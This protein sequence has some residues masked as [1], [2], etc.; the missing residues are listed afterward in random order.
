M[1]M[2]KVAVSVYGIPADQCLAVRA[3]DPSVYCIPVMVMP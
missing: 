1:I 2:T 3:A